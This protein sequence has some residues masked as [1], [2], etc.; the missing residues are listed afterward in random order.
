MKTGADCKAEAFALCQR[1]LYQHIDTSRYG[2]FLF[3]SRARDNARRNSDIDI[4]LIGEKPLPWLLTE[5]IREILE[6]SDLLYEVD[7][8]DFSQLNDPT[9][10]RFALNTIVWWNKLADISVSNLLNLTGP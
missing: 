9:F 7:L 5:N 2:I 10:K 8:V 4:G 1:I 6:E 3:G